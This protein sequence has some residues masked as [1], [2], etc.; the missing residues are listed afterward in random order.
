MWL[1]NILRL[2]CNK[3]RSVYKDD[4][5]DKKLNERRTTHSLRQLKFGGNQIDFCSNDYLG[6]VHHNSLAPFIS[7]QYKNGSTGSRLLAGNYK[8]IE[9]TE[10]MIASF[11]EA[12]TALI[13]NSG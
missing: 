3:L 2:S 5:L 7:D 10:Q 4:F 13:F 1:K 8:M 12:E 11:H 9:E 6:I